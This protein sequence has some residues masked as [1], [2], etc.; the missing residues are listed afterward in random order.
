[1]R[2][3]GVSALLAAASCGSVPAIKLLLEAGADK[4]AQDDVSLSVKFLHKLIE[5]E[6]T[7]T[8][9]HLS[10]LFFL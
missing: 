3:H 1:L 5:I 8:F 6:P 7:D 2:Q 10:S 4:D 9:A